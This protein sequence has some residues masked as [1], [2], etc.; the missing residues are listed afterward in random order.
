L[1]A[2]VIFKLMRLGGVAIAGGSWHPAKVKC[3]A[4]G[5]ASP[6]H[7]FQLS[8]ALLSQAHPNQSRFQPFLSLSMPLKDFSTRRACG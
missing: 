3:S 5:I 7:H 4:G 8:A 2:L 6:G 1:L